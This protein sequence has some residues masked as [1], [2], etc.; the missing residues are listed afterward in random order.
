MMGSL[1]KKI[2]LSSSLPPPK[3]IPVAKM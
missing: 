1:M 3:Y 2:Y